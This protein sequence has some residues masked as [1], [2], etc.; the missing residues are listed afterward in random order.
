MKK[1]AEF[2]SQQLTINSIDLTVKIHVFNEMDAATS[3]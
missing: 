3:K 1:Q 2:S